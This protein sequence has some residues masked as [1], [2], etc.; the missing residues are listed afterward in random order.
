MLISLLC[1]GSSA[2]LLIAQPQSSSTS[3]MLSLSDMIAAHRKQD[4]FCLY[5][6]SM[7][8]CP[9]YGQRF[10]PGHPLHAFNEHSDS[11]DTKPWMISRWASAKTTV[12]KQHL[13]PTRF[14]MRALVH[15]CARVVILLRDP[16]SAT[17]SHCQRIRS[18]V[19]GVGAFKSRVRNPEKLVEWYALKNAS[20]ERSLA[21]QYVSHS[22]FAEGWRAMQRVWPQ[23]LHIIEFENMTQSDGRAAA[24]ESAIRW[25]DARQ[26]HSFVD[27]HVY[28]VNRSGGEC[29]RLMAAQVDPML[30]ALER[31]A[32]DLRTHAKKE[33]GTSGVPLGMPPAQLRPLDDCVDKVP[34]IHSCEESSAGR[35]RRKVSTTAAA[36]S[37]AAEREMLACKLTIL[38]SQAGAVDKNTGQKGR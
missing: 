6:A 16:W 30:S 38:G 20:S 1:S 12:F 27:H 3:A 13:P 2:Y 14:H 33:S 21:R 5:N 32:T 8:H 22:M 15:G 11:C 34:L 4:F 29:A 26:N 17:H 7:L 28:L 37:E 23:L 25:W 31:H 19:L 24:L 9:V 36:P 10:S 35:V 18:E